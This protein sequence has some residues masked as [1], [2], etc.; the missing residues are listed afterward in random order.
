LKPRAI[1]GHLASQFVGIGIGG[2]VD[3]GEMAHRAWNGAVTANKMEASRNV[4]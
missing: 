1:E 3:I 2:D 4:K